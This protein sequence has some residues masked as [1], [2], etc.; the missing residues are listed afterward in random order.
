MNASTQN[1]DSRA[2]DVPLKG[3]RI[4]DLTMAWAGPLAVRTLALLGADVIKVESAGKLDRW[5]GGTFVQR[6]T[7]RYPDRDPGERPWNRNSFFNTQNL[8][9]RAITLDLK[10]AAGKDVFRELVRQ[11]DLVAE[12]F[13]A[14]AMGRL[15]LDYEQLRELR[16]DLVMLSMPAFGRTGPERD[17][18]AHGPTIEEM[19]GNTFAQ[20]YED[21]DPLPSGRLAWGDPVAG[22]HGALAAVIALTHRRRTGAGQHIDLAHVESAIPLNIGALMEQ[23]LND[24]APRRV[25]NRRQGM[26][27]HGVFPAEGEDRWL[28]I[29]CRDDHDW[30]RLSRAIGRPELAD[31]PDFATLD[32]RVG[33]CAE[34]DDLVAAWV[35]KQD[36]E[37]AATTLQEAGVPAGVVRSAADIATDPQLAARG[38]FRTIRH[39]EAGVHPYPGVPWQWA[40]RDLPTAT[41]APC[42]GQHTDDVLAEVVGLGPGQI[43]RLRRDGVISADPSPQ[44]D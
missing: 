37:A 44:G 15:G 18:I 43:K 36:A 38:F 27:P 24:R 28:S 8:N 31:D 23:V 1:A 32:A 25:G 3:V 22:I 34:I 4:L 7:E 42:L 19:A 6:G 35:A 21:G 13:G 5:R 16:H 20:G 2:P 40:T 39:P 9:K 11:S 41:P 12:N 29:A 10:S 17:H 26:H 14:G 30:A 33:H